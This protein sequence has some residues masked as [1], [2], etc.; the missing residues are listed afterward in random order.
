MAQYF[1]R[2]ISRTTFDCFRGC[3]N[4]TSATRDG[5]EKE[6]YGRQPK[7]VGALDVLWRKSSRRSSTLCYLTICE[8]DPGLE[9]GDHLLN[10][11]IFVQII[12]REL[13]GCQERSGALGGC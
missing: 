3:H 7:R 5:M 9:P 10:A 1:T 4:K 11:T 13:T 12:L 6:F 2:L 8:M